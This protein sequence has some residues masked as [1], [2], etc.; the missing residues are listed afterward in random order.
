MVEVSRITLSH[1]GVEQSFGAEAF[2]L[3]VGGRPTDEIRVAADQGSSAIAS[4][5]VLD[6]SAFIQTAK[7]QELL[8]VNGDLLA[9]SRRIANGD[10]IRIASTDIV[11][12]VRDE[13]LRLE[14]SSRSAAQMP[15]GEGIGG[16]PRGR[17]PDVIAPTPFRPSA[18]DPAATAGRRARP[19]VVA[20]WAIGILLVVLLWFSFTAVSVRLVIE[21][22]P[23]EIDLPISMFKFHIGERYLLR[24]G[25][26]E[27]V[28]EKTGYHALEATLEVTSAPD[29]HF[30]LALTKLPGIVQIRSQP[31][32]GAIA[33][34]DDEEV[35]ITPIEG[36]PIPAGS[37]NL[38]V[39][40][41]R[42]LPA[43]L[44]IEVEGEGREQGFDVVLV[45]A[46]APISIDSDPAHASVWV[47]DVELGETPGTFE[48]DA[49][50]RRIELRLENHNPW[51][52][53]IEVMADEPQ[54]L[55]P[56][57]LARADAQLRI[58]S[59]PS[60]AQ[61]VVDNVSPGRT[62]LDLSLASEVIHEISLFKSG[63]E[64][65][66]RSIELEPGEQRKL[67][68]RL[69]PRIGVIE[70]ITHPAG[71]TLLIDGKP[72]GE[73][74]QKLRL[75]ASP[76]LLVIRKA[77]YG[78]KRVTVTPRP[79]FPQRIEVEL[80]P[81]GEPI[82]SGAR[83]VTT[84]LGQKLVPVHPGTFAMGSRRGEPGR[85]PNETEWPVELT[86]A[87]YI[88]AKEVTNGDFR[89]FSPAHA[90]E[91]FSGF[92][93]A[94]G[95]QPAV[96]VAWRDA[97]R[98]CNWLSQK[99]GLPAAYQE[100]GGDFVLGE[101]VGIGYRLP[102]EAEW[103]WA[104][105][106]A[107]GATNH[108]FPWGEQADPPPGSGNYADASAAGIVSSALLSYRDGFP[109]TSPI[110]GNGANA[111]GLFDVGGNVAEWV[112]DRYRI[113]PKSS[114]ANPVK[115]PKGPETGGLRV[116]RGSSWKHA[117]ETQLRLAFRDYG[118]DGREDVGFRIARY[119]Q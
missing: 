57:A 55:E 80:D 104:A 42:H 4:V 23:D 35:G 33:T 27:V 73:A 82:K 98:F 81:T 66:S 59:E 87:F 37:H 69:E 36:L 21:P 101:P 95:E 26:H 96:R 47:D 44:E 112:H 45:P 5:G 91:P 116:I 74:N 6:G 68:I 58:E 110:G 61:I 56:V 90:P 75:L 52:S 93:L 20:T 100:R 111:L 106:F 114:S 8:Y 97:V 117:G 12:T 7:S 24:P 92:E 41:P 113:Y 119:Q 34:V 118:K 64:L 63:H 38:T 3:S 50:T 10:V 79:D 1:D 15:A 115:D 70:L 11:C 85:R 109:V 32:D 76:H 78:E 62:P 22:A 103:A 105:R 107:A 49:G 102:T 25:S 83:D 86:R 19:A 88:S 54:I 46:W 65:A 67:H 16:S 84:V 99:E 13:T 48:L 40:A 14:W 18:P 28:A 60:D 94:G 71:A 31:V 17:S 43:T 77:G 108:P 29:Q 51:K 30:A 89:Q 9:G 2:P 53:R 39:R 72:T